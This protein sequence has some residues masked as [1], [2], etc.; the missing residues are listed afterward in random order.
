MPHFLNSL[1][2][3]WLLIVHLH[4]LIK[5]N[6]RLTQTVT[7]DIAVRLVHDGQKICSLRTSLR[8]SYIRQK[9][10]CDPVLIDIWNPVLRRKCK[11]CRHHLLHQKP[12]LQ[13]RPKQ[14]CNIR[15]RHAFP[16]CLCNLFNDKLV[17]LPLILKL[18]KAYRL[19]VRLCSLN[20]LVKALLV[21]RDQISSSSHDCRCTAIV[22]LQCNNLRRRIHL[23]KR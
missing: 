6:F 17:L 12:R 19:S 1:R 2:N 21:M 14:H 23:V 10:L 13:I 3:P 7:P 20:L 4:P 5:R 22:L 15:K 11:I 9:I 18:E 8:N 16:L